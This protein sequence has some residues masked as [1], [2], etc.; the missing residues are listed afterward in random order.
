LRNT[1]V[2]R[3]AKLNRVELDRSMV[4]SGALLEG[5][6]GNTSLGDHSELIAR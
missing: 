2:G 3:E 4:G 1:I 6:R 5:F